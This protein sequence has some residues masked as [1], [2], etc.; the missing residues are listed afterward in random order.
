MD[1]TGAPDWEDRLANNIDELAEEER[2]VY[3]QAL[4][5]TADDFF[6][7]RAPWLADPNSVRVMANADNHYD[8][9]LRIDG[10]YLDKE[11]AESIAKLVQSEIYGHLSRLQLSE[12][13]GDAA[14]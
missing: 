4:S 3:Q 6:R 1:T 13:D 2:E 10:T 8:V 9:V 14:T 7:D 5:Q 12:T 11:T